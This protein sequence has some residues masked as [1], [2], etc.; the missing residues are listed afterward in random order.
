VKTRFLKAEE[1][2]RKWFLV[3]AS[4]LPLGRVAAQVARVLMGKHR[5]TWTPNIDSGDYVIVVNAAKVRLTGKKWFQKLH[6]R[7][8]GWPGGDKT[9]QYWWM[10]Q[11]RPEE[12][13]ELAVKGMLP[14]TR[15]GRQ[16]LKK[17]K[18]FKDGEHVFGHLNPEVLTIRSS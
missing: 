3:D 6:F 14:K 12:V 4:D 10:M 15:L 9:R 17:L 8:S 7:H 11:E 5:P 2:E 16:M 1:V 18:V 13:M